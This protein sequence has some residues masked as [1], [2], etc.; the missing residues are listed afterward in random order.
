MIE[1]SSYQ[2]AINPCGAR[3]VAVDVIFIVLLWCLA[4]ALV[5]PVGNFPLDDDWSYGISAKRMI[6]EN[7]FHPTGWTG[8]TLLT[9]TLWGALFCIPYGFSFTTLR[10]STLFL[11][12]AGALGFYALLR[13]AQ[14]SRKLAVAGSLCLAF[15]PVYFALSNT[16]MTDVSFTAWTIFSLLFF[17]KCLR[18]YSAVCLTL[19]T[20]FALAATLCRQI[21]IFLPIAFGALV[22][23]REGF[24]ARKLLTAGLPNLIVIGGLFAF[25][26]WLRASARTPLQYQAR[27]TEALHLLKDP[28]HILL[29]CLSGTVIALLYLG[30][31]LS[32]VLGAT[33]HAA[34]HA[35]RTRRIPGMIFIVSLAAF[36]LWLLFAG[37]MMPL[38]QNILDPRGIGPL[39]LRDTFTLNMPTVP[40]LPKWFW[41]TITL[42]SA[43]GAAFALER[44]A[45]LLAQF[46]FEHGLPSALTKN[47]AAFFLLGS[48]AYFLP[49]P[50]TFFDRYLLPLLP[51][52]VTAMVPLEA[53]GLA[54]TSR[55]F[56]LG[57]IV[58]IVM[59]MVFSVMTTR[60]YL[61]WNRA[62]WQALTTLVEEEHIP[63][64]EIDG[65]FEF[66]GL[67]LYADDYQANPS[68]SWWWV[69][70]D[71]YLVASGDVPGYETV[72]RYQFRR[73][74]PPGYGNICVLIRRDDSISPPL[75][76]TKGQTDIQR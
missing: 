9:H 17:A 65:G 57:T 18:R 39:T 68:K 16:F 71:T 60:D 63:P 38:G 41:F 8:T 11:G 70:N 25:N 33:R 44:L 49:L 64:T 53:K 27:T 36:C 10:I 54:F 32:P 59:L 34:P 24:S 26:A 45:G 2:Q 14:A 4:V 67:Y 37:Q 74:L 7:A 55:R 46:H 50:P 69:N 47:V 61:A 35:D 6:E 72:R 58:P 20:G 22:L 75:K 21:G 48:L 40:A 56:V 5:N 15:N 31:F 30:L 19:G 43:L 66:N 73:L 13:D 28:T 23:I 76:A 52:L 42:L 3:A 62:R 29:F 12:L 51:M 1:D